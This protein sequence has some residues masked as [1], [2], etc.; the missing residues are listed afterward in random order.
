MDSF[1]KQLQVLN[2][3]PS[4][5]IDEKKAVKLHMVNIDADEAEFYAI[6]KEHSAFLKLAVR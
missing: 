4:Q 2:N 5:T 6:K 3:V 1:R